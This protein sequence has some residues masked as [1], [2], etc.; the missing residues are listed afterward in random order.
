MKNIFSK[1]SRWSSRAFIMF[2]LLISSALMLPS[3]EKEEVSTNPLLQSFGP[4][5]A[6]R[7]VSSLYWTKFK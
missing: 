7:V 6:L 1:N 5:P 2:M 3:C 4:S